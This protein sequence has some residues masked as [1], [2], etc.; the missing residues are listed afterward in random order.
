HIQRMPVAFFTRT[1]TGALTSRLTTDLTGG[2]RIFTETMSSVVGTMLGLVVTLGAMF[3]LSWKL[4]LTAL[5]IAPLFIVVTRRMRGRLHLLMTD[6]ANTTAALNSQMTERF[7]VG[8]AM[9]VKLFGRSS[10]EVDGFGAKAGQLRDIGVS[11]AVYSRVFHVFFSMVGAV[12]I[13]LVYW[14]GGRMAVTGSL[15]LGT[16][17]AFTAYLAQLYVPMTMLAGA[18]VDLAGALVSFQRVF[19]VLDFAP[20]IAE[21]PGAVEL[22]EARGRV[23]LDG[24]WFRY[25]PAAG[26]TLT[27]LEGEATDAATGEGAWVLRDVSF[28]I[29]PGRTVALVG[30]SG[31]G[32]T[33]IAMLVPR[34]YDATQGTVRVDGRDVR[35]L[36]VASLAAATGMVMQ[37]PHLFHDTIRSNLLY[38]KPDASEGEMVE[39][40]RA[41]RIHDLIASL[42][43]GYGT[44]VGERG[45]RLSGGEKQRVAIA[46]LLLKDP[47]IVVLDEATSHLDSE[48]ELAIQAALATALAGRSCLVIAH[49]LSTVVAADRILVV[50]GGRVVEQGA[51]GELLGARGLYHEL[52]RLQFERNLEVAP[53]RSWSVPFRIVGE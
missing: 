3:V 6:Q 8:G 29:E 47:A 18:R 33:T 34:L 40:A 39:A 10:R 7:Q 44:V 1:Q 26:V 41:A 11:A 25:P 21:R 12:G 14:V 46:R 4:T 17:V 38:A 23:E 49:R 43:D 28:T 15:T 32:K 51:H 52:W 24:V 48:S 37:D 20:A 45:Y 9:L 16:L 35:D 30:P 2:H 53:D 22:V 5:A 13:G 42:P 27:S 31:A 19:E 36:T 50:D